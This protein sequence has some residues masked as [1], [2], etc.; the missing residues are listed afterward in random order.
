MFQILIGILQNDDADDE[1]SNGNFKS[2]YRIERSFEKITDFL[3]L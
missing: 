3:S 1:Q 2:L